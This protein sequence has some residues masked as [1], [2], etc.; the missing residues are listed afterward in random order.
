LEWPVESLQMALYYIKKSKRNIPVIFIGNPVGYTEKFFRGQM[1]WSDPSELNLLIN[2][3]E[4]KYR[5]FNE[6]KD[7]VISHTCSSSKTVIE[8]ALCKLERVTGEKETKACLI[9]GLKDIVRDSLKNVNKKDTVDIL[10]WG[11]QQKFLDI[12]KAKVSDYGAII[13]LMF[14]SL[15][16]TDYSKQ[17]EGLLYK[18]AS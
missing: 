11:L 5:T 13:P 18:K 2:V 8:K 9:E 3:Y 4:N 17:V 12:E 10:N 15:E 14:E 7:I 6:E 1:D 16:R